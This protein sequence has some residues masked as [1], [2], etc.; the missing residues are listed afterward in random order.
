MADGRRQQVPTFIAGLG[1]RLY[2]PHVDIKARSLNV[3]LQMRDNRRRR[4]DKRHRPHRRHRHE[5]QHRQRR[6]HLLRLV[7]K[8]IEKAQFYAYLIE[9]RLL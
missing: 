8:V 9:Y 3:C 2:F 5:R 1:P 6:R 4:Q 7:L